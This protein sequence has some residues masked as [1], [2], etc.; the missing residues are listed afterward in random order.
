[1]DPFDLRRRNVIMPGD[2]A[3][4]DSDEPDDIEF[5][6]SYGLDQCLD[7]VQEALHR[8]GDPAPDGPNWQVG[9]GMA[10]A[11]IAT[12]PPR[13]HH[14][15]ASAALRRTARTSCGGHRRVRQRHHDGAHPDRVGRTRDRARK[16]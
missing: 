1:M 12:I 8:D 11:M 2:R 16:N 9:E 13:G 10:A 14:A 3:I 4:A 5:A 7:L 15:E 6:G